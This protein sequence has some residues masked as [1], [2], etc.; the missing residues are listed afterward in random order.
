[1][2]HDL[3]KDFRCLVRWSSVRNS[4]IRRPNSADDLTHAGGFTSACVSTEAET[5]IGEQWAADKGKE[6]F[7]CFELF[8]D[9]LER[10]FLL[11]EGRVRPCLEDFRVIHEK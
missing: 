3:A 5:P 7:D 4:H 11:V 2:A 10:G 1:L 6:F 9:E 8:R